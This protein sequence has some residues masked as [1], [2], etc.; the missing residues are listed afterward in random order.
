MQAV[1]LAAG[2]SSRFYPFNQD[3]EHKSMVKIMG[4]TLLEHTLGSLQC[5]D[6]RDVVIVVG[7]ESSIQ[8]S[9]HVPEGMSVT[10]VVQE[11]PGGMGDA[12]LCAK[13]HLEEIF[14]LLNAY[15]MDINDFA[16]DMMQKQRENALVV[17]VK[18][19]AILE[20]Y[21]NVTLAGDKMV[22]IVEKPQTTEKEG[23][24]IIGI[25]LLNKQFALELEE[26]PTEEYH[27]EKA[28]GD[29]AKKGLVTAL[30][31]DKP[32]VTLKYAWDLLGVKDYL[33]QI[34]KPFRSQSA[35]I[36]EDA[37]VS[38]EA[39]IEE[40][41]R[42]LEGACI[43]GRCYI[44]AGVTI[45]NRSIIRDRVVL[46]EGVVIGAQMEMKNTLVMDKTT[47][48][49]G[50]IGDSVIGSHT[51]IA[52]NMC[53]ANARLDRKSV[54]TVVKGNKTNTGIRHLGVIVGN[55]ANLGIRVSTMPGIIVGNHVVVG[56]STTVMRNIADWK[57]YFTK[58]QEV[59]EENIDEE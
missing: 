39:T 40:G 47:T 26:I 32:T 3:V 23:H 38:D 22:D 20:H 10:Y 25:Y 54:T 13:E 27:F 4:K 2:K 35:F 46:E 17:L 52:A 31:T 21:G 57:K 45:G 37:S 36:A 14:F 5:V 28:L 34:Q 51:K 53:T 41:A 19:D 58:F 29:F 11:I 56:P 43:K 33:L 44:G 9:I 6:I 24:R 42:I 1:I 50:F 48:H 59:I 16:K 15:H 30:Q 55:F 49:S 12:L 7:K 8:Q 18:K